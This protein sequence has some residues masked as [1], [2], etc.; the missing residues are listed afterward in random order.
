[1]A[2]DEEYEPKYED[3]DT[4]EDIEV[5]EKLVYQVIGQSK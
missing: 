3:I 5:P 1:M 4:T 2:E